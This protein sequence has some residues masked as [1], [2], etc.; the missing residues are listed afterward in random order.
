MDSQHVS[1]GIGDCCRI[2]RN[3]TRSND[4]FFAAVRHRTEARLFDS[5]SSRQLGPI[6]PMG[7][8]YSGPAARLRKAH[9]SDAIRL[10]QRRDRL[11]PDQ[12]VELL[13][14]EPMNM[15]ASVRDHALVIPGIFLAA[16]RFGCSNPA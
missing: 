7:H 2:A 8:G 1:S 11:R 6:S 10:G 15:L 13:A 12:I 9:V 16:G 5:H 3:G 4:D 14:A